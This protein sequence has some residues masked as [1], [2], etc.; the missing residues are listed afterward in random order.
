MATGLKRYLAFA[1][2]LLSWVFCGADVR[3]ETAGD[4]SGQTS[5]PPA[6]LMILASLS[7]E[8]GCN[9]T[10][11]VALSIL[12]PARGLLP[13]PRRMRLSALLPRVRVSLEKSLEHDE[14][15]DTD[16]DGAMEIGV[17][18]DD[19][20]EIRG[21]VQWDLSQL[22]FHPSETTAF[23]KKLKEV[24]RR[25]QVIREVTSVYHERKKLMVLL[26]MNAVTDPVDVLSVLIRVEELTALLDSYTGGWF[27]EEMARRQDGGSPATSLPSSP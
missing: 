6:P 14:S 10:L 26:G 20:F 9:E 12:A 15:L 5:L 22:A 16:G 21:Y 17:D 3:A 2:V 13:T 8:P 24:E 25:N 7:W 1:A 27:T 18:T 19:D 23:Q 4:P 11:D